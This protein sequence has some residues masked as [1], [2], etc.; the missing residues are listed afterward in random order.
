[1]DQKVIALGIRM[2]REKGEFDRIRK[3]PQPLTEFRPRNFESDYAK[4]YDEMAS[5][6]SESDSDSEREDRKKFKA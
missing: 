4:K 6:E 1:M 3:E 5:D 2:A